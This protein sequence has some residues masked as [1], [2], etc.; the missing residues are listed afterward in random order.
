[1]NILRGLFRWRNSEFWRRQTSDGVIKIIIPTINS[2]HYIDLILSFYRQIQ[3]PV[4]VFVDTKTT[5]ETASVAA[6]YAREV[7]PVVN[8]A[9]RVGEMIEG[10]SRH[11][12][13]RWVLRIDDD[14]L[15]SMRMLEFVRDV[16]SRDERRV[17]AFDRYQ[18]VFNSCG[19]PFCSIKHD[20]V[21]HRQWRLYR[22][23][24]VK[25]HGRGHTPGFDFD[26]E[27]GLFAPPTSF[28]IHLDWVVHSR[29]ER[30]G[31]IA[32]YDAHTAGHGMPFRDYY[33][34]DES[35]DFRR[36]LRTLP[37]LEFRR[38]GRQLVR[39]FPGTAV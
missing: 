14:E 16:I 12:R 20:P 6:R 21:T 8:P 4:T 22:P 36:D 7:I 33:L 25:F 30:L 29:E 11:C 15:P 5:D 24:K 19:R 3:I 35:P 31:K 23:D 17:V 2:A 26:G 18:T 1:M 34:A 32:R 10:M 39:R 9:A 38:V 37:G 13:T 28:M 27:D